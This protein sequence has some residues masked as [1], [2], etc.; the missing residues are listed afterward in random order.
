MNKKKKTVPVCEN[1]G[2]MLT[3]RSAILLEEKHMHRTV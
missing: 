1:F 2:L 3:G